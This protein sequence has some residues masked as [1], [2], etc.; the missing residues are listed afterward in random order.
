MSAVE[1]PHTFLLWNQ[2]TRRKVINVYSKEEGPQDRAM[3]DTTSYLIEEGQN[4][5]IRFQS[6]DYCYKN[7]VFQ[8]WR[9]LKRFYTQNKKYRFPLK[10]NILRAQINKLSHLNLTFLSAFYWSVNFLNFFITAS[11]IATSPHLESR[12]RYWSR[13]F[14]RGTV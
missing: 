1:H 2:I 9:Y 12:R 5:V 3:W 4:T 13:S 14:W 8:L 6:I 7:E 10:S 11:P